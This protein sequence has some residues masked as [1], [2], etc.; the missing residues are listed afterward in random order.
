MGAVPSHDDDMPAICRALRETLG[1]HEVTTT[2]LAVAVGEKQQTVSLWTLRRE[3]K[4]DDLYKVEAHLGLAHGYLTAR[5]GYVDW[6]A[7]TLDMI[8]RDT[9]LTPTWRRLVVSAYGT[10]LDGSATDRS[11][12]ASS[13]PAAAKTRRS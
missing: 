13:A 8:E 5:A 2:E 11:R 1:E 6:P 4:L 12:S 7:S 3:P 10:A 9:G